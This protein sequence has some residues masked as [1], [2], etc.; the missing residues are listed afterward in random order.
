MHCQFA[1]SSDDGAHWAE[2]MVTLDERESVASSSRDRRARSR[3]YWFP[4][5]CATAA[6]EGAI[7]EICPGR[8][9]LWQR[10]SALAFRA[11]PGRR[12]SSITGISRARRARRSGA[13]YGIAA[14]S[15]LAAP[16]T[17]DL[18]AHVDFAA[19]AE[20]ARSGGAEVT[21]RCRRLGFSPRS[22]RRARLAALLRHAA[23]ASQRQA[24]DRGVGA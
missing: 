2:R 17:A 15:V 20:A 22:G 9:R 4:T 13:L 11:I 3:A 10:R 8:P 19:F 5:P 16:G 21:A 6:D 24:L 18:S 7:V 14:V 1:S 12:S 23:P